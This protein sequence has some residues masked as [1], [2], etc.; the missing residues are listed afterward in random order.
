MG[1][2]LVGDAEFGHLRALA[3]GLPDLTMAGLECRL[4]PERRQIDLQLHLPRLESPDT[5]HDAFRAS[6]VRSAA[7]ERWLGAAAEV[8]AMLPG[9]WLEYDITA[10]PVSSSD[11]LPEPSLFFALSQ[12]ESRSPLAEQVLPMGRALGLNHEAAWRRLEEVLALV[13][14]GARVT[15]VGIMPGRDG[16]PICLRL[17]DLSPTATGSICR[18]VTGLS[19]DTDAALA[20]LHGLVDSSALLV[21]LGGSNEHA[22]IECFINL[23]PTHAPARWRVLLDFLDRHN[24]CD[25]T[26]LRELLEW[27]GVERICAPW[28]CDRAADAHGNSSNVGFARCLRRRVNHL[29]VTVGARGIEEVKA[30]LSF[31]QIWLQTAR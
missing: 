2:A 13:P 20:E 17:T 14:E 3:A 19:P 25:R 12:I 23:Q 9:V 27:P 8:A 5:V 30:Y 28:L 1:A 15:H 21:S 6:P 18:L 29:K 4:G 11:D 24:A 16:R 31:R 7:F 26:K 22:G 10:S